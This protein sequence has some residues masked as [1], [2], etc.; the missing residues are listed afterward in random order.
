MVVSI[1]S[2]LIETFFK[3][4]KSHGQELEP[5]QEHSLELA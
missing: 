4:L 3:L 2:G 1:E 5:W